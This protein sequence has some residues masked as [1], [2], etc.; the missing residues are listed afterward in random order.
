ML[1]GV[2]HQFT[3]VNSPWQNGRVERFFG[4]LKE[5]LKQI[6]FD[7]GLQ[8]EELLKVFQFWY[9]EARPHQSLD[10]RTPYEVWHRIDYKTQE[11]TSKQMI[12]AWNGVL[13][14]VWL[15]WK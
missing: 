11:P 5:K 1:C 14:G 13:T 6:T 4:T 10:G 12:S 2:R 15:R 7:D 9:N 8:L 3:Q